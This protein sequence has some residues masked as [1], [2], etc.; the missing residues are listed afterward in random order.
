MHVLIGSRGDVVLGE[1]YLL[2]HWDAE[3]YW[4]EPTDSKNW[5]VIKGSDACVNY[6][7]HRCF[8]LKQ[9]NKQEQQQKKEEPVHCIW[10]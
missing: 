3:G 2:T 10:L 8:I 7:D 5:T 4:L 1:E 9:T 6:K